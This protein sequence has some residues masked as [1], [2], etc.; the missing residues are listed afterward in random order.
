MGRRR[1]LG[2]LLLYFTLAQAGLTLSP[3]RPEEGWEEPG[4]LWRSAAFHRSVALLA[5]LTFALPSL[6]MIVAN[7]RLTLFTGKNAYLM[8]LDSNA[9]VLESLVLAV[10]FAVAASAVREPE[11]LS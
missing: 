5:A 4:S 8:G 3:W 9:D 11:D 1:V 7:Y 6:Y 2:A 10:L